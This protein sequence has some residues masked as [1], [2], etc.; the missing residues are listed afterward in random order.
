M[1]L[2]YPVERLN[3]IEKTVY[4]VAVQHYHVSQ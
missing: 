2:M 3:K 1:N 4:A